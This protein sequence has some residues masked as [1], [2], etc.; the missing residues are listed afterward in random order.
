MN[1]KALRRS[2]R[3]PVVAVSG[4]S[5]SVAD[6]ATET[7]STA[8]SE[9]KVSLLTLVVSASKVGER[10]IINSVMANMAVVVNLILRVLTIRTTYR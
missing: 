10:A 3:K 5:L 6:K 9:I 2:V 8:G 1:I 4:V 7:E